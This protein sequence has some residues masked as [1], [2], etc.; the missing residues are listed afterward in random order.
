MILFINFIEIC[1]KVSKTPKK[2]T[3]VKDG[4]VPLKTQKALAK[5]GL[6]VRIQN[7]YPVMSS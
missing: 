3:M 2:S 4:F 5:Q 6:C 7:Y 1:S